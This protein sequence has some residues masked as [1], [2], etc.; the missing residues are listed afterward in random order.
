MVVG[1]C[2]MNEVSNA[3]DQSE[4]KSSFPMNKVIHR[5]IDCTSRCNKELHNTN[6]NPNTL[7]VCLKL[8][9]KSRRRQPMLLCRHR[10]SILSLTLRPWCCSVEFT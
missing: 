9:L 4:T 2:L 6:L 5:T 8:A 3:I 1:H 7:H 10:S